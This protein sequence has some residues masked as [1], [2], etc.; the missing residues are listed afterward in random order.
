MF[1]NQ[2]LKIII[3]PTFSKLCGGAAP[4][5]TFSDHP[6][7]FLKPRLIFTKLRGT[8]ESFF[9]A[10]DFQKTLAGPKI[11]GKSTSK[12][13]PKTSDLALF[14]CNFIFGQGHFIFMPFQ[15]QRPLLKII[16]SFFAI[17]KSFLC[18]QNFH[19]I[20]RLFKNKRLSSKLLLLILPGNKVSTLGKTLIYDFS[21][22]KC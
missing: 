3:L 16:I 1:K 8:P 5:S 17:S 20:F 6:Q 15:N 7:N 18:H 19:L 2:P 13:H 14:I 21:F 10:A 9:R 11:L 4:I 22:S 12:K